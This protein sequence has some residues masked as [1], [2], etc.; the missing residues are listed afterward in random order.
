MLTNWCYVVVSEGCRVEG[1]EPLAPSE[2][3]FSKIEKQIADI[4][5]ANMMPTC[6]YVNILGGIDNWL[7][8]EV[9]NDEGKV[10][11]SRYGQIVNVNNTVITPNSKVD[12]QIS[13]EQMVIFYEK[14]LAFVA[15]NDDGVVTV[16]CVGN[17]PENSYTLQATVTEVL[18]N[19]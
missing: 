7:S 5:K 4:A 16:Y 15:E 12:L 14:D 8:E 19:A 2:D 6:A 10:I 3:W 17:I 9:I 18:T 1:E 11:G 13:S